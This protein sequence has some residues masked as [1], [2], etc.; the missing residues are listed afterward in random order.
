MAE[1]HYA[2]QIFFCR[3]SLNQKRYFQTKTKK[4][5]THAFN[6]FNE[7]CIFKLVSLPNLTLSSFEFLDQIFQKRV[8]LVQNR[9]ISHHNWNLHIW[10][11]L[12]S[13]FKLKLTILI[14]WSKIAQNW[15]SKKLY[16]CMCPWSLFTVLNLFA[17][18]PTD[19]TFQ[20]LFSF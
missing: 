15:Y 19:M 8:F 6:A 14:F 9:K 20:C 11:R 2:W 1:I 3:C 17:R 5:N 10:L 13:K 18:W 4:A 7:F 16:F 12:G